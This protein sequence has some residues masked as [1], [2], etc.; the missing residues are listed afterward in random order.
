MG[1]HFVSKGIVVQRTVP[2]A[3]QQNGKSERYIRT[4]EEGG[5]ALLADAG[6]PMTFWLDAVLTRQ[7]LVNRLP[8]S[9]LPDNLTPYELITGGK[10]DL[11]HL[12][13]WGCDCYVAV[14]D[15]LRPKA[16]FKRFRAIFIGY[17][18]H[19]ISWRVPDLHGKYS[20]S[21]DVIFNESLSGRLGVP[22]PLS[23]SSALSIPPSSPRVP[24]DQPHVRTTMG[25]AYDEVLRLKAFRR[26]ARI[27]SRSLVVDGVPG[28]GVA[29][30]VSCVDGTDGGAASGID[31]VDVDDLTPSLEALA[32]FYS[33]IA[34]SDLPDPVDT[35]S[36]PLLESDVFAFALRAPSHAFHIFDLSK[37]PSSYS[38]AM[39]RPDASV[40]RAAMGREQQSI[41]DMGAFEEADL[42]KGAKAVGLKWVFD[43]KT[44]TLGVK[45]KGK[46]K[47]R[48]VAQ[49][50]TTQRPGQYGETYAPVAKIAS[51]QILLT[52]AAIHDLRVEISQFDCKTAFLHAKLRHDLYVVF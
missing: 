8:T 18:E 27:K 40:W 9:T 7:Y 20:F 4:I 16:G 48:L 17:E 28:G 12:R 1:D 50:Y 52:W 41:I 3:H 42:P 6:L 5:Q 35:W 13:V 51:V 37:A 32:A 24:R 11:S 14:P 25:Q 44:D 22:R 46:E 15:E 38:E 30:R 34:S 39:A 29:V 26:D 21:N 49:G 31:V 23:S 19:R 2:Y 45:I 43:Y 10:P 36:L 33:L 47:A